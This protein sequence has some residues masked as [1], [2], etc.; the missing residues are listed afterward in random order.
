MGNLI[1]SER[2]NIIAEKAYTGIARVYP[3]CCSSDEFY[4]F[5]QV[6]LPERNWRSWDDFSADR[7]SSLEALLEHCALE[8]TALDGQQLSVADRVDLGL[9][10]QV[11]STLREQLVD[12]A[13]HRSQPTFHLTILAAGLSE[14]LAAS[15]PS[16]WPSRVSGVPAFLQQAAECLENVPVLFRDLGFSMLHDLQSWVRGLSAGGHAV[17]DM[18]MALKVFHEALQEVTCI[19]ECRLP[20]VLLER[21][22]DAH[23]DCRA[24]VAEIE[25][26]LNDELAEME[27]VLAREAQKLS[28]RSSWIDAVREMPFVEVAGEGLLELYRQELLEM[29]A[30]CRCIGLVPF[31]LQNARLQVRT[32]P[33]TLRAIRASDSYAAAPGHPA[34]G[35]IFYVMEDGRACDARPGRSLEYRLT[36]IHEAWPGHHLLDACRWSLDRPVRRPLEFPL[37][38]EGWACLAEELMARTGYLNSPWD[39]FLLAKRRAERAAR[40]LVD[41]GLQS[42]RMKLPEAVNLLQR[43]GYPQAAAAAVV[44]KYLLRPGYQVCYTLGLKQALAFWDTSGKASPGAF[45][46]CLLREGEIGFSRL[47]GI[48]GNDM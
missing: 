12:F 6:I 16:A 19:E 11:M 21:I 13:P 30:H 42:G 17:G 36:A 45:A 26:I 40:G 35:G 34:Q 3:V 27:E 37:F 43:V 2:L 22:V 15:D 28:G 5:P 10:K 41:M 31:D 1:H 8:L 44:P 25:S 7:I 48:V 9:L 32:V 46:A 33:E 24:P 20:E 47:E 4:F 18:S 38:Y 39:R 23:L 14:A 29:E